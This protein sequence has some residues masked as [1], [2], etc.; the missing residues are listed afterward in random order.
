MKA[1]LT[2]VKWC[3]IALMSISLIISNVEGLF[4]C[5]LAVCMSSL[6]KRLLV[7]L[8][9]FLLGCLL[10]VVELDELFVYFQNEALASYIMCKY[11][12]T[13]CSL[14]FCFVYGF[15]CCTKACKFD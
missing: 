10:F 8:P 14:S 1:I 13:A 4:M 5:L 6:D 2:G 7:L 3:L 15:L 12:L 9:I 11:F